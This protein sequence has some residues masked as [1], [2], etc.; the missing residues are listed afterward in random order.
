[1]SILEAV[2]IILSLWIPIYLYTKVNGFRL[3]LKECLLYIGIQLITGVLVAVSQVH[4]LDYAK[5]M[6]DMLILSFIIGRDIL[7][8]LVI[9]YALF[10]L[11]LKEIFRRLLFFL[12]LP[13]FGDSEKFYDNYA[14]SIILYIMSF[15]LVLLFLRIFDYNFSHL[16]S[17]SIRKKEK[18]LLQF[19]NMSMLIYYLLMQVLTYNEYENLIHTEE[20]RKFIVVFYLLFFIWLINALDKELRARLQENLIFQRELQVRDLVDYTGQIENLYKEVRS[21]RH[22]YNNIL[23]TIEIG[24]QTNDIVMIK[25]IYQSVLK[26]S[27]QKFR[28]QKYEIGKLVGIKSEA[29]KSLLA[30]KLAQADDKNIP[31]KLEIPSDINQEGMELLDFITIVSILFDNAIEAALEAEKPSIGI[32]YFES[33]NKQYFIITNAIKEE[34]I[35]IAHL[36]DYG[37]S[38]KGVKRGIGLYNITKINEKYQNVT[39][40]TKSEHYQ[41]RQ[42][43]VI[44]L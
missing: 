23:R 34:S 8:V 31:V 26:E 43:L 13:V 1:M 22:D 16:K 4:L 41:F 21:F 27:N 2:D 15:L 24:I 36:Y 44:S 5:S 35:N 33:K 37:N 12:I 3:H 32:A 39:L 28:T 6:F 10:P 42:V 11:T 38:S 17:V 18:S 40:Q 29:L 19:A 7:K 25:S 14:N 20:L 30:A 9:F